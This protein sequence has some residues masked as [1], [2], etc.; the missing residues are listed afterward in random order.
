MAAASAVFFLAIV[1]L[2][3]LAVVVIRHGDW[4][5]GF[6]YIVWA[7]IP[8]A[9]VLGFT[10]RVRCRVKTTRSTACGN[11]AYG[12]LFGCTRTAGHHWGKLRRRL[13]L[14]VDETYIGQSKDNRAVMY[15][16]VP[17][18]TQG[19]VTIEDNGLTKCASWATLAS[20]VIAAIGILIQARVL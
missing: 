7:L 8:L 12:L 11:E 10:W 20:A 4:L 18:K 6:K 2:L 19:K 3:I 1:V 9:I 17:G 16:L 13:G 14:Q 5:T 15:Q